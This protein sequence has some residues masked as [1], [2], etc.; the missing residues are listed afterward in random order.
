[1]TILGG[2]WV[3]GDSHFNTTSLDNLTLNSFSGTYLTGSLTPNFKSGTGTL[4][5]I[6]LQGYSHRSLEYQR[7]SKV[8]HQ[9][10]LAF[11][12]NTTVYRD[13]RSEK[14]LAKV[15]RR[16]KVSLRLVLKNLNVNCA[17]TSW[18]T[19]CTQ[20][21]GTLHHERSLCN[22]VVVMGE[23][24]TRFDGSIQQHHNYKWCKELLM[25]L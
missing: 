4:Y 13:Q 22:C 21:V 12:P 23:N 17:R 6:Y 20:W 24:S 7:P 15:P 2:H 18:D 9:S 16:V 5:G 8:W 11:S 3:C 1:M 10:L 19:G 25:E 14:Q